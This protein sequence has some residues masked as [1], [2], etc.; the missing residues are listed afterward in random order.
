MDKNVQGRADTP[1]EAN[2]LA[3]F[4]CHVLTHAG[5]CDEL[6]FDE[7]PDLCRLIRDASLIKIPED[8]YAISRQEVGTDPR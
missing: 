6:I 4:K 1:Q 3:H 7:R 8:A 2:C 5:L